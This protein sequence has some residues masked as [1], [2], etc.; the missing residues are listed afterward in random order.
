MSFFVAY[1]MITGSAGRG[2]E[3]ATEAI[4]LYRSLSKA[5]SASIQI[6][7]ETGKLYMLTDLLMLAAPSVPKVAEDRAVL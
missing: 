4:E 3:T 5:G 1:K 7:D 6:R 2:V